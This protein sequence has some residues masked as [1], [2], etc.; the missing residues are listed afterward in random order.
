MNGINRFRYELHQD[1]Y[2]NSDETNNNRPS[3]LVIIFFY[4]IG[5][6]K[7][8]IENHSQIDSSNKSM[9]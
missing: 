9:C 6:H 7:T 4:D 2:L 5:R 8:K 3:S 1:A